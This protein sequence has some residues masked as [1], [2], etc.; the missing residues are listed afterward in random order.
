MKENT[1]LQKLENKAAGFLAKNR[2]RIAVLSSA[3]MMNAPLIANAQD[4]GPADT[5]GAES[6]VLSMVSLV[7]DI[8]PLIG[9]FFVVAGVFKLIM[10]YRSDNPEGQTAAAKDIVIGAIFLIFRAFAW[11]AIKSAMNTL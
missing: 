9:I 5:D 10:A 1:K 2:A 3:I 8:F 7:V 11:P 4:L 6:I